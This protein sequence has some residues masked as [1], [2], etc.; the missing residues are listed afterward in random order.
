MELQQQN[1]IQQQNIMAQPIDAAIQAA[2]DLAIAGVT[3]QL[4]AAQTELLAAR[5]D[6][7]TAQN[8]LTLAQAAAPAGGAAAA[9]VAPTFALAPATVSG[10]FI[11][12]STPAGIKIFKMAGEKLKSEFDLETNNFTSFVDNLHSRAIEQGWDKALLLVTQDGTDYNILKNYGT[13]THASALTHANKYAFQESRLAQ[14]S[15]N[16]FNCLEATLTKEALA[17]VNAEQHLF[18]LTHGNVV[19]AN[20]AVGAV[21]AGAATDEFRCGLLLLWSIINRTTAQTNATISAIINQLTRM[22]N[23]MEEQKHDIRQFNTS[24]RTLLNSYVANH[25]LRIRRDHPD[26]LIVQCI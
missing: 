13:L 14:N 25:L 9:A 15:T 4:T 6:L 17:I 16:L 20:P 24:I 10:A 22:N 3:A 23:I 8:A 11:D 2:I 1:D 12:Y 26:Q 21:P 5:T 19:L 18:T 7:T